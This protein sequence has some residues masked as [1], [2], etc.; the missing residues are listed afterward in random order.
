MPPDPN[1]LSI[2]TSF[3]KIKFY[4]KERSEKAAILWV[5][6][7]LERHR[8]GWNESRD[9]LAEWKNGKNGLISRLEDGRISVDEGKVFENRL[10]EHGKKFPQLEDDEQKSAVLFKRKIDYLEQQLKGSSRTDISRRQ[11]LQKVRTEFKRDRARLLETVKVE[12]VSQREALARQS[13]SQPQS[14]P[15]GRG[16]SPVRSSAAS[17]RSPTRLQPSNQK[18]A[19]VLR[20]TPTPMSHTSTATVGTNPFR[21][22]PSA[23]APARA[24]RKS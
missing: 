13:Q 19:Q 21:Q 17:E 20:G 14:Q 15:R 5:H 16:V 24:K 4:R 1:P 8:K 10:Q 18:I 9:N 12:P 2:R 22:Q 3:A 23:P 7:K 11:A 6:D